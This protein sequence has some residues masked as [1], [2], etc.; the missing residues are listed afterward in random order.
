[1]IVNITKVVTIMTLALTVKPPPVEVFHIENINPQLYEICTRQ[2]ESYVVRISSLQQVTG[3]EHREALQAF[4]TSVE[5]SPVELNY[6]DGLIQS[7]P[8]DEQ[9]DW[10]FIAA[11]LSPYYYGT[12]SIESVDMAKRV[13]SDLEKMDEDKLRACIVAASLL[14]ATQDKGHI[15]Y[16]LNC[17][18][19]DNLD[20]NNATDSISLNSDQGK[21]NHRY[22]MLGINVFRSI[23][24]R[25]SESHI[26]NI[27]EAWKLEFSSS[28]DSTEYSYRSAIRKHIDISLE[29]FR[30]DREIQEASP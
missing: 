21:I 19:P 9:P 17:I 10:L 4:F 3:P 28:T 11:V 22:Y 26:E 8:I 13:L 25:L 24:K 18:H 1:M 6:L 16:V 2:Y 27:L 29:K 15:D 23:S 14:I 5:L 30:Q 20:L 12:A 7:N